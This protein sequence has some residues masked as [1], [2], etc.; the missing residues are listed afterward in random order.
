MLYHLLLNSFPQLKTYENVTNGSKV[1]KRMLSA[2]P[3]QQISFEEFQPDG[4]DSL[5]KRLKVPERADL[6]KAFAGLR[7]SI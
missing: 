3:K 4:G 6:Y 7:K 5:K 1:S 2:M